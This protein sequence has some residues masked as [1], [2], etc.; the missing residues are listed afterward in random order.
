[1][2]F[3]IAGA[4][5]KVYHNGLIYKLIKYKVP[6]Y[7][8][9]ILIEFLRNRFFQVQLGEYITQ[10]IA[11]S[12]GTPQGAVLSPILFSIFIND[13]PLNINRNIT[14]S[15]L[16]ADDLAYFNIYKTFSKKMVDHI[17]RHLKDLE[18]W[19]NKWR[20]KMAAHKCHY[21]IFSKHAIEENA[22]DIKLYGTPIK[23]E[24]NPKFLG[25]TFDKHL[26]FR[27]HIEYI[28]K[29]CI[30]RINITKIIRHKSW[31]LNLKT[32][33]SIYCT[34]VRSIME[35]IAILMPVIKNE[36]FNLLQIIQNNCLRAIFNVRKIDKVSITRLHSMADLDTLK[37]RFHNLGTRYLKSAIEEK[38]P[39]IEELIVEYKR[40]KGGRNLKIKTLL[41]NKII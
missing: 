25:I 24:E 37:E 38:N 28:K 40:F 41:C 19:L 22:F 21:I 15:I 7:L 18:C 13:I 33:V 16:F 11:I 3:D 26:T 6:Y 2:F 34:L 20:L 23:N 1:M 30:D 29:V 35:Y 39:L 36:T 31:N 8:V 17:N 4:F 12:T 27:A 9:I 5:D 32:L 14:G 10:E